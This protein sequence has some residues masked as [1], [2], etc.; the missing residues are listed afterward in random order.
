MDPLDE[1]RR[2]IESGDWEGAK[3]E[4]AAILRADPENV[5]A[6]ML[7]A[8]LVE[9]IAQQA[10]CYRQALQL[11]PSNRQA[12]A[13][14]R[15]LTRA[16]TNK[17]LEP[18]PQRPPSLKQGTASQVHAEKPGCLGGV[19]RRWGLQVTGL[20]TSASH[21]DV[22]PQSEPLSPDEVIELAGGPLPPEER[23]DCPQCGAVIARGTAKCPW[24]GASF[25]DLEGE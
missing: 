6:W 1:I 16:L 12:A 5:A 13:R 20:G 4:T 15:A 8:T 21:R 24:C 17:A 23:R 11:D 19:L 18:L 14:L 7:L 3:R 9:D 22:H 25:P 2:H 10:D